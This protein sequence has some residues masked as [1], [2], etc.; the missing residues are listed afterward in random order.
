LA[1]HT[2]NITGA[3]IA[4]TGTTRRQLGSSGS[5]HASDSTG[6]DAPHNNMQPSLICN[7]IIKT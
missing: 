6:G 3:I 1:A 4:N 5:N 2:H 7:Y